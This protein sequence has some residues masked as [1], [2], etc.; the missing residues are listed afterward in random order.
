MPDGTTRR[1]E[2]HSRLPGGSRGNDHILSK[3]RA[4]S[5]TLTNGN[6]FSRAGGDWDDEDG[7]CFSRTGAV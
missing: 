1:A 6:G 5:C 4:R 2:A 3:M 7:N